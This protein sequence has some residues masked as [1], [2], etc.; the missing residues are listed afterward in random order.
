MRVNRLQ[1]RQMDRTCSIC[2]RKFE[3][4]SLLRR[5]RIRK[6][7]CV[8]QPSSEG[9]ALAPAEVFAKPQ[10]KTP[11]AH[12][13]LQT[14]QT[15]AAA[16]SEEEDC[17]PLPPPPGDVCVFG[18]EKTEH[19]RDRLGV[20][21]DLISPGTKGRDVIKETIR[22][23]WKDSEHPHNMCV[24]NGRPGFFHVFTDKGWVKRPEDELS[25]QIIEHACNSLDRN[26]DHEIGFT[27]EGLA[28]L[29]ARSKLLS[30]AFDEERHLKDPARG[31]EEAK[32]LIRSALA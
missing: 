18:E 31:K 17:A 28:I 9:P 29:E 5:H 10:S 25:P 1:G 2:G 23:L 8:P 11:Q 13:A 22:V 7:A 30:A 12:S 19:L 27:L 24:R 32:K 26:Q 15:A 16:S 4:P 6:K 14:Q 20:M 3:Y 21:L